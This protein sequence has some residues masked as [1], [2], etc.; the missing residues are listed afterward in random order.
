M[1]RGLDILTTSTVCKSICVQCLEKLQRT[2][3]EL[4]DYSSWEDIEWPRLNRRKKTRLLVVSEIADLPVHQA[5]VSQKIIRRD[6]RYLLFTGGM[7][8]EAWSSRVP[9]LNIR[10]TQRLHVASVNTQ[11][12]IKGLISRVIRG[13]VS[14]ESDR[15]V[16]GW[17]EGTDF[18]VMSPQFKRLRIP[19]SKLEKFIGKNRR[20]I[21]S[22]TID[23]DGSYI[24][25]RHADV[26]LGWTQFLHLYNPVEA[27]AAKARHK[28]F[29][30]EYGAAIKEVREE[31]DLRQSDIDGLTARQVGRI[32]K[33]ECRAMHSAL[34]KLAKA[35]GVRMSEYLDLLAAKL[36]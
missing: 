32:E 29:N 8:P 2:N 26:H 35:H 12:E 21:T 18:V 14:A 6:S 30:Q 16:H 7:R 24:Y 11:P 15:I 4:F 22:C 27:M 36:R 31:S 25:W 19:L 3:I 28:S 10:D 33:G 34:S 1:A 5:T 20:R 17:W 23:V 9:Q 13:L